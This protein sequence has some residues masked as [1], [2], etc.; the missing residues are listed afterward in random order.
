MGSDVFGARN[1]AERFGELGVL[2]FGHWLKFG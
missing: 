2:T 1:R